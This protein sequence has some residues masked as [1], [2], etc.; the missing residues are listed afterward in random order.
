[1]K[2]LKHWWELLK[3]CAGV[4]A[5]LSTVS[6]HFLHAALT[7]R[8]LKILMPDDRFRAFTLVSVACTWASIFF[9]HLWFEHF[10]RFSLYGSFS[11]IPNAP[12]CGDKKLFENFLLF[13]NRHWLLQI[14]FLVLAFL[15]FNLMFQEL[16]L[17][18]IY[19]LIIIKFPCIF[20]ASGAF[21]PWLPVF[22]YMFICI[23]V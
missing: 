4:E 20:I 23:C 2:L 1:M 5:T 17:I 19:A 13:W 18:K 6:Q 8:S 21:P 22:L 12:R 11:S 3:W 9:L 15:C 7:L 14:S 16:L 10:F